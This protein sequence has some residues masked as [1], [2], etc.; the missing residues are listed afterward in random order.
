MSEDELGSIGYL[1]AEC[2]PRRRRPPLSTADKISQLKALGELRD[3]GVLTEAEFEL[4]KRK[5]LEA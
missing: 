3:G 2:R 1:A 4:E 5:L